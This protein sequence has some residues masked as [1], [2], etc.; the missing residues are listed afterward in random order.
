M[1]PRLCNFAVDKLLFIRYCKE[2]CPPMSSL[3][4]YFWVLES[5]VGAYYKLK[6][7]PLALFCKLYWFCT[8]RT[9]IIKFNWV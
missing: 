9:A 8:S 3:T 4:L 1:K 5:I 6:M 2:F 7:D